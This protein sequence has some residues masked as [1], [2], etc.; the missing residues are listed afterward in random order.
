MQSNV[1]P[2]VPGA[3]LRRGLVFGSTGSIGVHRLDVGRPH[4]PRL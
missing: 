2:Q 1:S 4:P 3:S